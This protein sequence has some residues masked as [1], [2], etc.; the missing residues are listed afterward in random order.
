M[1]ELPL[2]SRPSKHLPVQLTEC[3]HTRRPA[4]YKAIKLTIY[5]IKSN[6]LFSMAAI[7]WIKTCNNTT[8]I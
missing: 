4:S 5:Q 6:S 2:F 8:S 3:P 7:S 1:A